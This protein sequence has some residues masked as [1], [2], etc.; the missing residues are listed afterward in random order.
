MVRPS[1]ATPRGPAARRRID[2]EHRQLG[3]LLR[4]LT[5]T[6]EL[7][8][9]NLQLGELRELL[10]AHFAGEEGEEGLHAVVA[11]GASHRLP[12]LQHLFEEHRELL[13]QVERL[14]ADA[15]ELAAGPIARLHEGVLALAESLRHH[16]AVEEELF[17]EAFYRDIGGRS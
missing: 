4:S 14:A 9:L 15:A 17:S 16:E 8:R 1:T 11:E 12:N 13:A 5:H 3:E 10:I 2:D 7:G 6:R